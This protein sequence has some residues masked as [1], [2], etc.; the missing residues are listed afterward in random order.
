M[1]DAPIFYLSRQRPFL[2]NRLF[3]IIYGYCWGTQFKEEN[4]FCIGNIR[5]Y[6]ITRIRCLRI[7]SQYKNRFNET[8]DTGIDSYWIPLAKSV[9]AIDIFPLKQDYQ[10]SSTPLYLFLQSLAAKNGLLFNSAVLARPLPKNNVNTEQ[11]FN[12]PLRADHLYVIPID[13][14]PSIPEKLKTLISQHQCRQIIYKGK[15]IGVA[16]VPES[17]SIWWQKKAPWMAYL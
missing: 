3:L 1:D 10:G 5:L 8:I 14:L 2:A 6:I 9:V 13:S 7:F 16:C 12:H 11:F 17:S 4:N 15:S